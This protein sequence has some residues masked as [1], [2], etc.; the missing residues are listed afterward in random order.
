M[1][2]SLLPKSK[3][4]IP[5][6]IAAYW[7]VIWAFYSLVI[8]QNVTN[9]SERGIL[10]KRDCI[11]SEKQICTIASRLYQVPSGSEVKIQIISSGIIIGGIVILIGVTQLYFLKK[12]S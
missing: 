4:S 8:I 5:I 10:K 7:L 2:I 3:N 12:K 1:I 9:N 6:Y 11:K